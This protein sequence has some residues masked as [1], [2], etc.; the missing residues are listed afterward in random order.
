MKLLAVI[1]G[2]IVG[3]GLI[4][5]LVAMIVLPLV[6]AWAKRRKK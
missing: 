6:Q 4:L 3:A 5:G 2:C 1:F